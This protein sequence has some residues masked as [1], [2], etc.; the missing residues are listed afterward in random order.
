MGKELLPEERVVS[1]VADVTMEAGELHTRALLAFEN[2]QQHR[3]GACFQV[4]VVGIACELWWTGVHVGVLLNLGCH[5][6]E[7]RQFVASVLC[8]V[9]LKRSGA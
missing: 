5:F 6:A 2:R 1:A 3:N 9:C 4:G 8:K 7:L